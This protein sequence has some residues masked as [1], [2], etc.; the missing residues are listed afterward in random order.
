ME[1]TMEIESRLEAMKPPQKNNDGMPAGADGPV[2]PGAVLS[3][4]DLST[5]V[6]DTDLAR[7]TTWRGHNNCARPNG[8]EEHASAELPWSL[9][10]LSFE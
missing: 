3:D 7:S 4:V 6:A 2:E 9:V 1:E 8:I 10:K 5:Q